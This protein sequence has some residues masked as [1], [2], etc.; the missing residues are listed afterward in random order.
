MCYVSTYFIIHN[1]VFKI[2]Y[3]KKISLAF[4]NHLVT[5][6]ELQNSRH[7]SLR[8]LFNIRH[9]AVLSFLAQPSQWGTIG[10][11]PAVR[12]EILKISHPCGDSSLGMAMPEMT[13]GVLTFSGITNHYLLL[14]TYSSLRLD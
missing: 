7:P 13:Y 3:S 12:Q 2:R 6:L 8:D 1:S 5:F 9:S 4:T 10:G 14:T 11:L